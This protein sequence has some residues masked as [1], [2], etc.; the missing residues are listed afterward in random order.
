MALV[1]DEDGGRAGIVTLQDLFDQ[2][3]GT[4]GE[5][6]S[7]ANALRL[8]DAGRLLVPG[9]LGST[10]WVSDSGSPSRTTRWTM[11]LA[12]C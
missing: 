4:M 2:V 6:N 1:V 11:S 12:S 7:P 5:S 9:T 8:D 10:R 3:A